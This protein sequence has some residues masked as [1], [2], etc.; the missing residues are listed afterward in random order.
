MAVRLGCGD[1]ARWLLGVRLRLVLM[2]LGCGGRVRRLR[3]WLFFT[4][5]FW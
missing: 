3:L 5:V 1:R 2:R 4:V